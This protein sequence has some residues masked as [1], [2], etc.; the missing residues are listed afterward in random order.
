MTTEGGIGHYA[1]FFM[2]LLPAWHNKGLL[3]MFLFLKILRICLLVGGGILLL[4]GLLAGGASLLS[5][6]ERF[7]QGRG[8]LFADAEAFGLLA[9]ICCT[10]GAFSLIVGKRIARYIHKLGT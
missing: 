9:L 5:A 1:A 2:E 7:Q 6:I 10:L 8:L 3:S 4:L